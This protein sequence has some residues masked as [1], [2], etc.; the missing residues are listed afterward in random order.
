M[1]PPTSCYRSGV[2]RALHNGSDMRYAR[3][4]ALIDA[5][6]ERLQK[7]RQLLASSFSPIE[8]TRK[9]KSL[10]SVHSVASE[11]AKVQDSPAVF[12]GSAIASAVV[13]EKRARRVPQ[14]KTPSVIKPAVAALR[15]PLGAVVPAAP[16]FVSA[17]QIRKTRAQRQPLI[18]TGQ[19]AFHSASNESL[20]VELLAKRWLHGSAS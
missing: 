14:R 10:P 20:T 3:I 9:R 1:D 15:T 16:V 11:I 5:E 12:H 17:E 18:R 8:K 19:S 2:V 6:V 4:L 13:R 7:A